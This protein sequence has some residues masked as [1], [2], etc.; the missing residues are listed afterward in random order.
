MKLYDLEEI[1]SLMGS[2]GK[3]NITVVILAFVG[4]ICWGITPLFV[5][6]GLKDIDPHIGLAIR[7]ATTTIILT[8]WMV[9][10][11]S[12]SRLT[13]VPVSALI[14]LIIEAFIATFV[15][16]LAYFAAIKNGS[17]SLVAII[18]SCSPLVTML[19]S[20]LFLH[21][22]VTA[23]KVIGSLLIISGIV[24]TLQ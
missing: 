24:V 1:V 13:A 12:F 15:G 5:K 6:L 19:L 4:M 3:S 7:T 23:A 17:V 16:D 22:A 20:M 18:L 2:P 11:G 21:E 8:G 10:D 9:A 14:F